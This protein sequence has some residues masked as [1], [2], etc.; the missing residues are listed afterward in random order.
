ML[1]RRD[2]IC[3]ACCARTLSCCAAAACALPWQPLARSGTPRRRDSATE[4]AHMSTC[5]CAGDRAA[6]QPVLVYP[7]GG[8]EPGGGA[9]RARH[10][11]QARGPRAARGAGRAH[12]QGAAHVSLLSSQRCLHNCDVC[13]L[14]RPAARGWHCLRNRACA[15]PSHTPQ[16]T[17]GRSVYVA[18]GLTSSGSSLLSRYI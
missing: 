2:N 11:G 8:A 17:N 16:A 10:R 3:C 5:G 13:W 18:P 6:A 15:L 7:R 14:R 1:T 4:E 12:R 9:A